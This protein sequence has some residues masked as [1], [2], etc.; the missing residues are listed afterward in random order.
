MSENSRR[1]AKNTMMLYIRMFLMMAVSLYTSRVVLEVLGV[2]D[3][4]IYNIVGGIVL[5]FT[6]V[7]TAMAT[8]TQRFLSFELGRKDMSEV[9]RVFSMSMT[10]HISIA[11]LVLLLAETIGLWF[12]YEKLNIP[13][14]RMY[15]AAWCYQFSILATC[16]QIVRVP[17]HACMIAY[18]RMSFYAYIS[19]LEVILRLLIVFLLLIGEGYDRLIVYAILMFVVAL[20]VCGAYKVIC[21]RNI[22]V[23]RYTFFWDL[24]LYK[25][26]M[27][28]SGW[29]LL[30]NA[31]NAGVQQGQNILLNMFYGVVLNSSSGVANQISHAVYTFVSN[32]QLAFNPALVKKYAEK[33]YD[34]LRKILFSTSKFSFYLLFIVASPLLFYAD[35]F[36]GVWLG[37]V[38]QYAAQFSRL[39]LLDMFFNALVA[40]FWITIQASGQI[41]NYQI[42][43]SIILLSS[44]PI[45]YLYLK[46]GYNPTVVYYSRICMDVVAFCFR[47]AYTKKIL[48]FSIKKYSR[49]VLLPI[50]FVLLL[51]SVFSFGIGYVDIKNV[52]LSVFIMVFVEIAIIFCAGLSRTERQVIVEYVKRKI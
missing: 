12:L 14:N 25:R 39:I 31:A 27:S 8:A 46:M 42:I 5:L 30:G 50:A 26:L 19:I 36:L 49:D 33:N 43:L 22:A 47:V 45:S 44:L 23:S 24:G 9:K 4:G 37:E 3:F 15:A 34:D 48:V 38:P 32:F 16:I 10:A 7:N 41:K 40:P 51:F 29:S 11:L 18:E 28:F 21:N 17:Y 13:E 35:Y 52:W 6:F 2:E 20:V 1:I